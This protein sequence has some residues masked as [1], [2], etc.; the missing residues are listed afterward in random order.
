MLDVDNRKRAARYAYDQKLSLILQ[1]ICE[2]FVL[3][4]F[5]FLFFNPSI[6]NV[7]QLSGTEAHWC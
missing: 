3:F 6:I 1:I 4:S 5:S 2:V 7:N